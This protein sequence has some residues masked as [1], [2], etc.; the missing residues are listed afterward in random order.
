ML[1]F[2][3]FELFPLPLAPLSLPSP[4]FLQFYYF[5]SCSSTSNAQLIIEL[6]NPLRELTDRQAEWLVN[7][8]MFL[9]DTML[10]LVG[11]PPF[12]LTPAPSQYSFTPLLFLRPLMHIVNLLLSSPSI[13]SQIRRVSVGIPLFMWEQKRPK[14]W[15]FSKGARSKDRVL[16]I[17]LGRDLARR[18]WHPSVGIQYLLWGLGVVICLASSGVALRPFCPPLPLS[19]LHPRLHMIHT[20][21]IFI[22][23]F[24]LNTYLAFVSFSLRGEKKKDL[25]RGSLVPLHDRANWSDQF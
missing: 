4:R 19:I 16:I 7:A 14:A 10:I 11:R 3:L 17:L 6:T 15:R 18:A 5:P 20:H 24:S 22:L 23:S 8:L 1:Y 13:L 2:Y 9:C 12:L 25:L 21:F